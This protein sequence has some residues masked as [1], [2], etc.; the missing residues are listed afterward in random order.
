MLGFCIEASHKRGLGHLY[1]AISIVRYLANQGTSSIV[2]VNDDQRAMRILEQ[3]SIAYETV[4]L[5]DL[6]SDWE[7]ALISKYRLSVWVNDRLDTDQ[8]HARHVKKNGIG[9]VTFDDRGSGAA[10]ADLHF[11]PLVFTG[12]ENLRGKKILTGIRFL[13]LNQEIERFA[14]IRTQLGSLV[15]T[16]G[17][18]DTYG[19][20][21]RVIEILKKKNIGATVVIGP[22]YQHDAELEHILDERYTL[23]RNVA[24]LIQEFS[25]HDL[26]ITGGG[27]TPFEANASG[28]PCIIIA[29]ELHEIEIGQYLSGLGCSIFAGYY[30][31]IGDESLSCTLDIEEMSR[32]G[33][34]MVKINGVENV[35]A[36]IALL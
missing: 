26:A 1:K 21:L 23:K 19:V 4:D 25:Y 11:A 22:S 31:S 7:T 28:L 29:N 2:M 32:R 9:L 27:V 6:L 30:E 15:V 3:H 35:C 13:V 17:G 8:R 33:M 12:H 16:L 20:T 5:D 34:E 14:R 24:S 36:E 10:L 18:S